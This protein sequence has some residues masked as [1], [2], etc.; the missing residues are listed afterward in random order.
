MEKLLDQMTQLQTEYAEAV[1][2]CSSEEDLAEVRVRFLGKKGALTQILR[3]MKDLSAEE[4]PTAG[5][6]ANE[7]RSA[8]EEELAER[9]E[10]LARQALEERLQ[11]EMLDITLPG[12]TIKQGTMHPLSRV[13]DSI[14]DAFIGL[15]FRIAEGPEIEFIRYN[16]DWL[17]IPDDHPSRDESDT[18][19]ISDDIVLRTQTSPVQ[20]RTML[21]S[22]PPLR[23]ICPGRVYRP[24]APDA[25]HSPIFYQIEGLAIDEGITMSDLVG[26]LSLFA[27]AT[28]G[29]DSEIRLRPHHFPF[30]EPSCE[31]DI[32]CPVCHGVDSD[33][34]RMCK[35]EGFIELL[36]GGMVHPDVL[37]N[38]GIDPDKYS[39]FAFGIGLER[40][41]MSRFG[42]KD[43]RYLYEND[44]RFLK[45]FQA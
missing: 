4:R 43:I 42:I 35:G 16:F 28:F 2:A 12:E 19:Y 5:A 24:D 20:M 13:M 27:H 25:T 37:R 7:L 30:T 44:L 26:C 1:T 36:G 21:A 40:T 17:E 39:G 11:Q 15:G 22:E 34:C 9:H 3:G 10:V 8:M 18:F 23:I 29:A 6:R 38:G 31:V 41:A 14:V 32:S 45:Q 33:A